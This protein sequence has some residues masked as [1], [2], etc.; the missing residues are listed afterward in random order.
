VKGLGINSATLKRE[1]ETKIAKAILPHID[2]RLRDA[3][4]AELSAA[5]DVAATKT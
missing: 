4:R 3:I 1:L 5:S 2:Q